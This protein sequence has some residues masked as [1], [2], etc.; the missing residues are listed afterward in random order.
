[1]ILFSL[2]NF[3]LVSFKKCRNNSYVYRIRGRSEASGEPL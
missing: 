2:E 3:T 1:M